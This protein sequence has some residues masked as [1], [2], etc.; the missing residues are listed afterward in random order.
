MAQPHIFAA[1][2]LVIHALKAFIQGLTAK[3][4]TPGAEDTEAPARA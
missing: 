4:P 3:H 2:G 1:I